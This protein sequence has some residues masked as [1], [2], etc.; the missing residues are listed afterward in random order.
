MEGSILLVFHQAVSNVPLLGLLGFGQG[1][2]VSS[3]DFGLACVLPQH[4]SKSFLGL[5][6]CSA[7][8]QDGLCIQVSGNIISQPSNTYDSNTRSNNNIS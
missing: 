7:L 1:S 2:T 4:H 5:R 8:G 6:N 3:Y